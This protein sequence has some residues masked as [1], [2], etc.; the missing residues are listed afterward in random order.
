[1]GFL[2]FHTSFFFFLLLLSRSFD[3]VHGDAAAVPDQEE[4]LWSYIIQL[5][6]REAAGGS[7]AE[8][9]LAA[10]SKHDWHL[11]FLEKPS[12]VP[13]VEQQKNAQQPLSSSRL[14]YSYHTVFDGFAAQLTVTEAASLRA[15]PGV[16]SV[17]ED[18]RV[19][20]HTTYSPK[21]LGLNLC[22]TGAW[23]RTGYGRGTIIGVLDTGVWP[24]SPSFDDRGMPPVPDRWRGACEAGEH[25][26]ASNCNRKLVGARFYSKGHRAANHPTDTAR[27]YAS[28]RDA[29]GHGTHTASTAAGSAVAG[30]T[31]LGAGTGEEEDGGTA[32]GVAPGAHVAAYKVCWFSGCFSSDILAG[33][34]D[35]VRDGVDV[36]S[37]SL[38]G[39]PIPLFE[40]SI[41]IGSFRATARGVSVVCAAGNNGPEPGTVAN[42]APW[43]L[44]VGASTMDRRFPAYVRLGDGRV[45]YGESMY[46]GKLHSKNGGNKEQELELVYAAGG[47]REAMYC[48]KGALSSAEVSGKMVVCDRG[49]TGR[50]DKGEA[51]REAGGAAMVLANTEIN[52]QEDS[53]DVH[54][55]PATLVGYKEAMELKSYISST[56]RAT[57]RLVFGGTR[58]GRARA[59]AVALFSSR[60]PSTTNP[61]VL[62]PDVVAP[63]VNIIAAWTGSVGPSGLDGDRDPRRSNFTVLSG[64]SMACPHVSGVAALVRS[65]HPSWSPAMVRS[66]IMTTADATDRRGK[67]IADDGA[68]G[69]GMPL[70]ADAFAMGAGH[71]SPARAVDPGLV[72]DVE[73]GDYVTHLCTLGYTEKEVF[74]VTHAGGVNCSD[75]LR[76][77]EGFTLNYPSISVAFKDAGGGSRKELR[78]TVTN[79]GAPNS[80][81]AVEVAAPAGVKVRVTP[82]TLV[83]AEFGEKKSFRVLVEAL[84]MGKDSADGYLVW[85]QVS[86]GQGRRRTVRSPIAVTWVLE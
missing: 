36:L 52:Q 19:E 42:E 67:P 72:Y 4:A 7:E 59:P 1:M 73:P 79:V 55:L 30:A 13:R 50:A 66:A 48:M 65:A 29:H 33:M 83:F 54:V 24:E 57:A 14:L 18:R 62:K 9:S 16:A 71:V 23:A 53:V 51:V 17:R 41:A 45:L 26:E 49:I 82:T 27:E 47:S 75:L 64:T 28:P 35:A 34:D 5:H 85:K 10:S 84:R 2:A 58:I 20:L 74:K 12:S 8:A 11:S 81:Y 69:D 39:F 37:L 31:V 80:T 78:R 44:T 3:P 46:P 15:H 77:N 6:P 70:P 22:P 25:F 60:G 40:D 38:G 61:S 21:F 68:F 32:R 63:G 43:V 56:P 76:E 86:G